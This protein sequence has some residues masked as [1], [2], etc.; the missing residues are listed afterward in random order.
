[1]SRAP[2]SWLALAATAIV[3]ACD[4]GGDAP[5]IFWI[6]EAG[7]ARILS[8]AELG[9]VGVAAEAPALDAPVR[10]L[11]V[12]ADGA[13]VVVQEV[14]GGAP[15][16]VVL[17]PSGL[18]LATFDTLDG[19][20]VP[21]FD[22]ATPPWAAAQ[23]A[24]G[25]VWVTGRPA[26]A[27]F[28]PDGSFDGLAAA[29]PSSTAGI[30]LLPDGRMLV[31]H[32]TNGAAAYSADGTTM[33]PLSLDPGADPAYEGLDAVAVRPDGTVVVAWLRRGVALEGVL[34]EAVVEP[35][36]LRAT[37]DPSASARLPSLSSSIVLGDGFVVAGPSL[38]PA[39]APGCAE[40]LSA[41][42]ATRHGC[43]GPG[44]HRG[45]ARLQ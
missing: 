31:T 35:G 27:I 13:V 6:G 2:V 33:E 8:V 37:G 36:V 12:L 7:A 43:L 21:L 24:D 20:G 9:A 44:A 32:G 30:A 25:R 29:L 23:A 42:L 39:A 5:A 3:G 17:S 38:G 34:V 28:L 14:G 26:P 19:M 16:A 22:P 15:P 4:C 41:D 40:L 18:R 45:I 10:A 11:A 1:V